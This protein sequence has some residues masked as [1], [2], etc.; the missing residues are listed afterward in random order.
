[1]KKIFVALAFTALCLTGCS[2]D[3]A[4]GTSTLPYPVISFTIDDG[5]E[6]QWVPLFDQKGITGTSYVITGD[7]FMTEKHWAQLRNLQSKGWDIGGHTRNHLILPSLPKAQMEDEIA[8]CYSDLKKHGIVNPVSFAYPHGEFN[9]SVIAETQKYFKS[10]RSVIGGE[11]VYPYTAIYQ[12]RETD[13]D[14]NPLHSLEQ[15]A[16]LAKRKNQWMIVLLH[17]NHA[18]QEQDVKKS[19]TISAFI[20]FVHAQNIKVM[21]VAEVMKVR[22]LSAAAAESPIE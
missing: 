13:G 8:G 11:N 17:T 21:T 19:Q 3:F 2:G 1:M 16:A 9:D 15:M 5:D 18:D 4:I 6:E 22:K 10:G 20:D 14:T 12:L 7:S